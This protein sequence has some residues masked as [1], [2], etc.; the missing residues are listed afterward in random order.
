[1]GLSLL[2]KESRRQ[3][4]GQERTAG[5][6]KRLPHGVSSTGGCGKKGAAAAGQPR[7][8]RPEHRLG[9]HVARSL[10]RAR[11]SGKVFHSKVLSEL[12][13]KMVRA[14]FKRISPPAPVE[15][16]RRGRPPGM[17]PATQERIRL[18]AAFELCGWSKRKMAPYILPGQSASPGANIY[19][20]C[21][22]HRELIAAIKQQLTL[23]MAHTMVSDRIKPL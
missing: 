9:R 8:S 13:R 11:A 23:E 16:K 3:Y 19:R 2:R 1:M 14:P 7:S 20:F 15:P 4:S 17:A 5:L 10:S 6:E 12:L 21:H 18:A 22:D